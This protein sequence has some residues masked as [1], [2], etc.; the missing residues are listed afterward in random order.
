MARFLCL[1]REALAENCDIHPLLMDSA[2]ESRMASRYGAFLGAFFF[3]FLK[4]LQKKSHFSGRKGGV[5]M[6]RNGLVGNS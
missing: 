3:F 5:R 4:K 6:F 1:L 2:L